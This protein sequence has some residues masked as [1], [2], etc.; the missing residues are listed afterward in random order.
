MRTE[1]SLFA[2]DI[3]DEV[4][5]TCRELGVGLVPYGPLE[6]GML[7]GT[8]SSLD[9][10]A[11]TTA[12]ARRRGGGRR[13]GH[14]PSTWLKNLDALNVALGTASVRSC[15]RCAQPQPGTQRR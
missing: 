10:L 14:Q 9:E 13:T 7:S 15:T 4:V 8:M 1:W 11:E 5:A 3:E 6:C 12:G 2:R